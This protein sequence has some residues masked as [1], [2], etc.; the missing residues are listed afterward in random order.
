MYLRGSLAEVLF[1]SLSPHCSSSRAFSLLMLNKSRLLVAPLPM[2]SLQQLA[3]A[4]Q[5]LQ[6]F[7]EMPGPIL[8]EQSMVFLQ[9]LLLTAR[10]MLLLMYQPKAPLP[11]PEQHTKH[12]WPCHA[13]QARVPL[14]LE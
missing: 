10:C 11:M 13:T 9:A 14:K 7:T 1:Y 4:A 5:E 3:L 6:S 2:E 8:Q 12:S